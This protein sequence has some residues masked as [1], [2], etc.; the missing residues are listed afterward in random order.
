MNFESKYLVGILSVT[1]LGQLC[2]GRVREAS[3]VSRLLF[4]SL[5]F[6]HLPRRLHPTYRIHGVRF[7][8]NAHLCHY[9]DR[10]QTSDCS[11]ICLLASWTATFVKQAQI[12]R[13][14]NQICPSARWR[15]RRARGE[16]QCKILH[17]NVCGQHRSMVTISTKFLIL[18]YF[19]L[20]FLV[21]CPGA[22]E[23]PLDDVG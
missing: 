21:R 7:Q 5:P 20:R 18:I 1:G 10:I 19:V 6:Y 9:L 14:L 23:I 17:Q 8:S 2:E 16:L 4:T 12:V 22:W 13:W 3:S 11:H 15:R